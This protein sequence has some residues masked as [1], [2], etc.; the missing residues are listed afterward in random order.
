[1]YPVGQA[2]HLCDPMVL[3]QVVKTS[4]PPLFVKHSLVSW[5]PVSPVPEYPPGQAPQMREPGMF[6]QAASGSQPPLFDA[7]SSTS[8]QSTSLLPV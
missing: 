1:V 4:Q 8:T 3:M 6:V 2:P 7:H 5:Q